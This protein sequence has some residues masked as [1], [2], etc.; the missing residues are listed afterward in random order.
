MV[1]FKFNIKGRIFAD[2]NTLLPLKP[3]TD[4]TLSTVVNLSQNLYCINASTYGLQKTE[5]RRIRRGWRRRRKVGRNKYQFNVA[6]KMRY[7]N[8]KYLFSFLKKQT[9]NQAKTNTH[10]QIN[11]INNHNKKRRKKVK[12]K[13]NHNL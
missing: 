10:T 9:N 6:P 4:H 1:T 13:R 3:V 11:Q 7:S 5:K 12:S 2:S 8:P